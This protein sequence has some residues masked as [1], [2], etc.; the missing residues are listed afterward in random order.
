[1]LGYLSREQITAILAAPDRRTWSG[2][3][4]AVLLATTYYT[5]ARVSEITALRVRDVLLDRQTAVLLHG[6]THRENITRGQNRGIC[7]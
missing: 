7:R 3:R 1:M 4:D 2:H 5:G 6:K